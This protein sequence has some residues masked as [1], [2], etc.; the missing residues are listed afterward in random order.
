MLLML[1]RR[2]VAEGDGLGTG[3]GTT[4]KNVRKC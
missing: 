2:H 1:L 3:M 4:T